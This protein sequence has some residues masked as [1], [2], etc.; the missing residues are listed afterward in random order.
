MQQLKKFGAAGIDYPTLE[1][2]QGNTYTQH[3]GGFPSTNLACSE[4][5]YIKELQKAKYILDFGC[6]VG[7][8]LPW[9]MEN[10]TATYVGL[11]P[12]T[13]M[14]KHIWQ[15]Q[16]NRGYPNAQEEWAGR[17]FIYN[18]FAEIPQHITFDY[19]VTTFVLQHLGYRHVVPGG[20]DLTGLSKAVIGKCKPGAVWFLLEHDSEEDWITRWKTECNLDF[21]VYERSYKGLPELAERDYTAPNGGHH[22][23]I[24]KTPINDRL[25]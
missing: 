25:Q 24:L 21:T 14:T 5:P 17:V 7:R 9:I 6:G 22:L 15:V 8:N 12:N 3:D 13:T 10:T 18:D 16:V 19:V 2:A 1:E 4:N 11:D 23:I 20:L